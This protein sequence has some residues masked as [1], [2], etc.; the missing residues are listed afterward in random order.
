MKLQDCGCGG[1]PQVSYNM[2]N[3]H[4]F[5]VAC[6]ACG[7][8]TPIC[9]DLPEAIAIWNKTYRNVLPRFALKSA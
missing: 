6:E 2:T 1:I 4:E 5:T 3:N 8:Q 7:N 9:E